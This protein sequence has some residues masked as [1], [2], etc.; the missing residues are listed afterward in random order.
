MVSTIEGAKVIKIFIY[1]V[2]RSYG[3]I[4]MSPAWNAF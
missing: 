3:K 1:N 4:I 2:N